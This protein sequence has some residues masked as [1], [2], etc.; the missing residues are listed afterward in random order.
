MSGRSKPFALGLL[1]LLASQQCFALLHASEVKQLIDVSPLAVEISPGAHSYNQL[2]SLIRSIPSSLKP[3]IELVNIDDI[4]SFNP[5]EFEGYNFLCD[6]ALS[7]KPDYSLINQRCRPIQIG[8]PLSMLGF[9]NLLLR[10]VLLS[11]S[12]ASSLD[13]VD[14]NRW[15]VRQAF[16]SWY[17]SIAITSGSLLSVNISNTQ[18]YGSSSPFAVNPSASG[19]S[20]QPSTAIGG[21]R[22]SILPDN[23]SGLVSPYT[24]T[25]SY[26]QAYPVLTLNWQLFNLAR[27]SSIAAS[28][29]QL[30]S[31]QFQ[32]L[33]QARQTV[34]SAAKL[35]SQLQATEYQIS[36][37]LSLCLSSFELMKIYDR[38]LKQGR[39]A[40]PIF[41]SQRSYFESSRA[42]L[43]SAVASHQSTLEQIKALAMIKDSAVNLIFPQILSLPKQ[44]SVSLEQTKR[45]VSQY[46]SIIAYQ[47]QAKQY[48]HLSAGS[49]SG[50][51]PLIS[52]LGYLTYI[53]TQGSQQYSPPEPPSGA[54]STQL[55]NYIGLNFTWNIFDGFSAAQQARSYQSQARS[56]Q[57]QSL[58]QQQSL[59][60]EAISSI[61][62][63]RYTLPALHA[64]ESSYQ[65]EVEAYKAY[66]LRMHAGLDDYSVIFQSQQ[67]LSTLLSS[68]SSTYESLF[69]AYFQLIALTGLY[70]NSSFLT[71]GSE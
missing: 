68:Y 56:Y 4:N 44:W 20:F 71:L 27:S 24:Q 34:L 13:S 51:W 52:V 40:N 19:T 53:G 55:S 8:Q 31:A 1:F 17:P 22:S 26:L 30:T 35:Y 12:I 2:S 11:P 67:M 65:A 42:Q 62:I 66:I 21:G 36:T 16:S 57:Q 14:S 32:A 28:K 43:L 45:L 5:I 70:F 49:Y 10:S 48:A 59:F 58:A 7:K 69:S 50:Y 41:L 64:I 3:A 54:W 33:D 29:D 25:S 47:H 37:L 23:D 38:Q 46:P 60:A 39:I 63:V 15:L 18:N 61:E 9:K 6:S